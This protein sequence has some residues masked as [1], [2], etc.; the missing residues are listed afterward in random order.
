MWGNY[1]VLK[2]NCPTANCVQTRIYSVRIS[3]WAL[4]DP[5]SYSFNSIEIARENGA[6]DSTNFVLRS[7]FNINCAAAY[8]VSS[9]CTGFSRMWIDIP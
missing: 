1:I 6:Q 2:V 8:K 9:G 5:S 3:K 7:H 4:L